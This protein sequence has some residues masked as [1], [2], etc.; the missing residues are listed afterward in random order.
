MA[1]GE[2]RATAAAKHIAD[3]L[4]TIE[5]QQHRLD[6]RVSTL[7]NTCFGGGFSTPSYMD[8]RVHHATCQTT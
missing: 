2:S 6:K 3:H 4:G 5:K 7:H 8:V 1:T